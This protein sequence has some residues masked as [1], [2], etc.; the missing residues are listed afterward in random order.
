[1]KI[2]FLHGEMSSLPLSKGSVLWA[3]KGHKEGDINFY[4]SKANPSRNTQS[5]SG[6]ISLIA[7]IFLA[8]RKHSGMD[9]CNSYSKGEFFKDF[10][11]A[12]FPDRRETKTKTLSTFFWRRPI[13]FG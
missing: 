10:S 12:F 5:P 7:F 3:I 6:F 11:L 9:P 2:F 1:M 8:D 4:R 13:S